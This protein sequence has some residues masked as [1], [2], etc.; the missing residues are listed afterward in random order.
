M[1]PI[2]IQRAYFTCLG[3]TE[4][5]YPLDRRLGIEGFLTRQAL[6]LAC[7]AG[8]R[9][10]FA[11]AEEQLAEMCGWKVSDERLRQACHEEARRMAEWLAQNPAATEDFPLAKGVVEFQTDAVKVNTDTGWARRQRPK[12]GT[13][14]TCPSPALVWLSPRSNRSTRLHRN[15][16][17][18]CSV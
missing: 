6:R 12:S 1:G 13:R 18:G 17:N 5:G 2:T 11:E 9:H 14:V 15:G 7:R 3:C 16:G 4:G 8:A 10:S